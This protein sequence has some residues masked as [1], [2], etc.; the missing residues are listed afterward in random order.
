MSK[1]TVKNLNKF[2]FFK[3][4]SAYIS[5][6][7]VKSITDKEA[8]ATV[9]HKWINQNPFKSLYWATQGM[10]SELATGI[11]V[12]KQIDESGKKISML[13]TKQTGTFTKKA[14]GRINFICKDVHLIKEAIEQTIST[15]AGQTL[16]MTAEGF[17][18]SGD[19]VSKFE[20]EWS[21]KVKSQ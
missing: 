18:E 20:Y 12:M 1:L 14:T 8:V 6:V 11:L 15:K 19:S 3:L 17:D 10:A 16:T 13:V 9:K 4:P 7:R 21:V 5:G 2:L